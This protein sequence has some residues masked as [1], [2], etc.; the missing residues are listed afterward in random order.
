[1]FSYCGAHDRLWR[2]GQRGVRLDL[3]D[4]NIVLTGDHR[5]PLRYILYI[6][7]GANCVRPQKR[8]DQI[9]QALCNET[10]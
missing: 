7:V 9:G 4:N 2:F 10:T 3:L 6:T 5:S 1:M 8:L